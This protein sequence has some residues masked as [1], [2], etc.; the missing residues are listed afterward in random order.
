MTLS[1]P[2]YKLLLREAPHRQQNK[3]THHTYPRRVP[4]QRSVRKVQIKRRGGSLPLSSLIKP[5]PSIACLRSEFF[6]LLRLFLPAL[7]S[8]AAAG[9]LIPTD[10]TCNQQHRGY[11]FLLLLTTETGCTMSSSSRRQRRRDGNWRRCPMPATRADKTTSARSLLYNAECQF[12]S[13]HILNH[14][15]NGM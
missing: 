4:V 14:A 3:N 6:S 8:S 9:L 12:Q 15:R 10:S 7:P 1:K 13:K 11:I 2:P 5:P